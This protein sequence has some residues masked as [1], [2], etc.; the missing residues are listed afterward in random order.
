MLYSLFHFINW[1]NKATLAPRGQNSAE[2]PLT[3]CDPPVARRLHGFHDRPEEGG[4]VGRDD[5]LL[6]GVEHAL[7]AGEVVGAQ[8]GVEERVWKEAISHILTSIYA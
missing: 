3:Q 8:D 7:E 4:G 6:A 2:E 5:V 1:L